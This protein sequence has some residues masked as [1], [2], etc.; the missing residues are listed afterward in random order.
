MEILLSEIQRLVAHDF[1]GPNKSAPYPTILK[2]QTSF[3]SANHPAL[4]FLSILTP[5]L[6]LMSILI[7]LYGGKNKIAITPEIAGLPRHA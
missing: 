4:P 2:V 3:F 5:L 6:Y 7:Y 1:G